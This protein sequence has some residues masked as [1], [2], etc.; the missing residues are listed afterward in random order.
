MLSLCIM[1]IHRNF[2]SNWCIARF[3]RI[4]VNICLIV[5]QATGARLG[6]MLQSLGGIGTGLII[7]F[8][9]SWKLT[10]CVLAFV[11]FIMAAGML[12]MKILA[13]YSQEGQKALEESGKV[14]T[15]KIFNVITCTC[16]S[17]DQNFVQTTNQLSCL[18]T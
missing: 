7:G 17:C 2:T 13:G 10:L 9:Y 4:D 3:N 11:P 1:C 6:T 5:L 18:V 14:G 15:V 8:I 16:L 12:Q